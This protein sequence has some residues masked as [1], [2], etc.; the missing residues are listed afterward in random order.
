MYGM[1][2]G[3]VLDGIER[4]S[5]Q[6]LRRRLDHE[7]RHECGC[8]GM[9]SVRGGQV[10]DSLECGVVHRLRY[11]HVCCRRR[12]IDMRCVPCEQV[13]IRGRQVILLGVCR[14]LD[15]GHGRVDGR[16]DLHGMRGRQILD[17]IER[18]IVH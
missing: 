12:L 18:G 9:Q 6:R 11:G 7:H 13:S 15:H 2:C 3:Q 10:L 8:D 14:G 5:M 1:R 16:D 4:G 17:G